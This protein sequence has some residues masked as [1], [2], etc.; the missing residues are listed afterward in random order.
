MEEPEFLNL[1]RMFLLNDKGTIRDGLSMKLY[2]RILECPDEDEFDRIIQEVME[3]HPE[4]M[5]YDDT[6]IDIDDL[7]DED[8]YGEQT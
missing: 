6:V 3:T 2:V 1:K 8:D 7:D 4:L 5:N